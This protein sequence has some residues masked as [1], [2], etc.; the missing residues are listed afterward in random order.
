MKKDRKKLPNSSP[1]VYFLFLFFILV[2]CPLWL[3][4]ILPLT[5]IF[6]I[7]DFLVRSL[8]GSK[9]KSEAKS[10]EN[11]GINPI[12][13]RERAFDIVIFGATGFTGKMAAVYMAKQYGNKVRWA[14]AGRRKGALEA[15][16]AELVSINPS[17]NNLPLIIADSSDSKSL[18]ELAN[19]TKVVITT[20]GPFGK[21]GSEL[22]RHCAELG[23]HYCDITGETD[24]VREMIDRHDDRARETGARIVHFCGHDCIPWDLIVLECAKK[25]RAS[26]ESMT[27]VSCFD[28]ISSTPSGGTMATVFHALLERVVYKST[29]GFDPLLKTTTGAKTT[30]KFIVNN[31]MSLG[32][33]K[34]AKA[35]IGPFAMASVMGNCVRR[36]N[37]VNN[38]GP[39]LTYKEATVYA[40][41]FAGFVEIATLIVFGSM[42]L[43]SPFRALLSATIL[44]APGQGAS[45]KSMDGGFLKVTAVAKGSNGGSVKATLYFPT[46]PG[47]RDTARMLVESGLVLALDQAE[48][49]VGGGVWTPATCQGDLLLKRLVATGCSY[50]ME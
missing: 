46:D 32:Y 45:E 28:Q 33:S 7:G 49:K 41:F 4:V 26:G 14:I 20:T 2:V 19:Q 17:L 42:L 44:P 50:H 48:M 3:V 6:F 24:W 8:S 13:S 1:A 11:F 22:V 16:R 37:A 47:Y 9:R 31:Q 27:E 43:T 5:I 35:W 30:N 25:L 15:I 18:A 21:Y 40:S 23:T 38:Y 34:V 10:Q 29:L 12:P 36:S 39:N